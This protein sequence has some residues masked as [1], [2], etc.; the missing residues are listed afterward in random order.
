MQRIMREHAAAAPATVVSRARCERML[1]S[2]FPH[3][4]PGGFQGAMKVMYD[5]LIKTPVERRADDGA[6]D[7]DTPEAILQA[8]EKTV[9]VA[10]VFAACS[11]L[12][13]GTKEQLLACAFDAVLW[14]AGMLLRSGTTSSLD[15]TPALSFCPLVSRTPN[16]KRSP[17]PNSSPSHTIIPRV[18]PSF[19]I[20][21]LES[22]TWKACP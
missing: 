21:S 15:T 8:E 19:Q 13:T 7:D 4:S 20:S 6:Y 18:Q 5:F 2:L 3:V 10:L 1:K 16:P 22:D 9:D 11:L 17:N 14:N 12:C